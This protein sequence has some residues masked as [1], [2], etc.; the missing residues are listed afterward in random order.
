MNFAGKLER[1]SCVLNILSEADV[2]SSILTL[3]RVC[4]SCIGPYGSCH[5]IHND[6][7]G[8]VVVTSA[9]ERLFS[10]SQVSSPALRLVISAIQRHISVHSDGVAV[11]T[12]LALLM[13]ERALQMS[14]QQQYSLFVDLFDVVTEAAVSYLTSDQCIV[15]RQLQHDHLTDFLHLLRGSCH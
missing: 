13:T 4:E 7:G 3:R 9:A 12:T 10:A 15:R 6:A 5:L 1:E 11:T 2:L 8:H 14:L